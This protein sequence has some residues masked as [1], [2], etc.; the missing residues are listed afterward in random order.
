MVKNGVNSVLQTSAGCGKEFRNNAKSE[1][2]PK[3]QKANKNHFTPISEQPCAL[4]EVSI[5]VTESVSS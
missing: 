1:T 2:V 3:S 4:E 5:A